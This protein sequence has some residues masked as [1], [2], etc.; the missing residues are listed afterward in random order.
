MAKN[1]EAIDWCQRGIAEVQK[2]MTVFAPDNNEQMKALKALLIK[3]EEAHKREQQRVER[4]KKAEKEKLSKKNTRFA[5]EKALEVMKT[6]GI[7]READLSGAEELT[8]WEHLQITIDSESGEELQLPVI[9]AFSEVMMTELVE[10]FGENQPIGQLLEEVLA[11]PKPWDTEGHYSP[12]KVEV[13]VELKGG[14]AD[15]TSASIARIKSTST[16]SKLFAHPKY[17]MPT[18]PLL[19]IISTSSP[20][21]AVFLERYKQQQQ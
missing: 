17:V 9:V 1:E 5:D 16:L 4:E 19:Q 18:F 6:R 10:K 20:F 2:T 8:G 3:C 21:R 7:K 11:E 14:A 13:Y 15:A 12:D